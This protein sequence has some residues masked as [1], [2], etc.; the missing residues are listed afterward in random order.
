MSVHRHDDDRER[1]QKPSF[2]CRGS[3]AAPREAVSKMEW[4][5]I[6][7]ADV[8]RRSQ[9]PGATLRESFTLA[10]EATGEMRAI[11]PWTLAAPQTGP[12]LRRG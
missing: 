8:K 12:A 7:D 5:R 4:D 2:E 10:R 11:E 3:W 9:G 1:Q 6:R